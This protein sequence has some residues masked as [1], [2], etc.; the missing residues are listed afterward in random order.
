M[1]RY[2]LALCLALPMGCAP[3]LSQFDAP[4]DSA[5]YQ[6]AVALTM[7]RPDKQIALAARMLE[8][9]AKYG[10]RTFELEEVLFRSGTPGKQALKRL[11]SDGDNPAGRLAAVLRLRNR[12]PSKRNLEKYLRDE[13]SDVRAAAARSWTN[14]I[15]TDT[16]IALLL[17]FDPR[18]RRSAVI[19]LARQ[20][21]SAEIQA[22]LRDTLQRDP[23]PKVRAEV[24]KRGASL[25][26][27]S[28]IALKEA[29]ID[30]NLGVRLVALRGLVETGDETALL[31]VREYAEAPLDDM[32]V[33]AAAELS[34]SGDP[35]GLERLLAGLESRRPGTRVAALLRLERGKVKKSVDIALGM[36]DDKSPL[37]AYQAAALLSKNKKHKPTVVKVLKTI[38]SKHASHADEAR[39]LL[40]TMGDEEALYHV[41]AALKQSDKTTVLQ[42]LSRTGRTRALQNEFALLMAS[43]DPEIRIAGAK[44]VLTADR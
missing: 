1:V 21:A 43:S 40:A 19:G 39:D 16:L 22:L 18:V 31:I 41:A 17:D 9:T 32:A 8:R 25:G 12:A 3:S 23:D 5:D 38:A 34:R 14:H 15:D 29:L 24:A 2:L 10:V 35:L 36:I 7:G 28:V 4:L 42:V 30:E 26:S 6:A 13:S 11:A 37:V 33:A 20:E 27:R 44:A